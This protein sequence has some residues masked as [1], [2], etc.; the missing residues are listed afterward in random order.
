MSYISREVDFFN[1]HLDGK[2]EMNPIIITQSI[3]TIEYIY[4]EERQ[5]S[6]YMP[7]QF[8]R[9]FSKLVIDIQTQ[10]VL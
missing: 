2:L 3:L 6:M 1:Q 4:T 8:V 7:M 5:D 10:M 9:Y